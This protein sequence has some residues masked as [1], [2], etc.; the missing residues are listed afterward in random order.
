MERSILKAITDFAKEKFVL[1][2]GPRQ[3]GKTTLANQWR[4]DQ[5]LY[6]NWDIPEDRQVIL[7]KSFLKPL[8]SN[9]IV[10]D[11]L[12]KYDRWKSWLKG[13]YDQEA[14]RLAVLVTGSARL[15]VF[16]KGQDSL[17]GR[18]ERL[19]L[20][21]LSIGEL[22]HGKVFAPP[23]DWLKLEQL[24]SL[25]HWNQ[26]QEFSGFPEP[27]LKAD[28]KQKVRWSRQRKTLLINQDL[29]D[30]SEVK[31]ISLV[32]HLALLLP[33]K[34]GSP[35]SIN[36][37]RTQLEV[38]HSTIADWLEILE[39]LYYCFRI[40]PYS[41]QIAR[42]I[43]KET[44]LYLWDWTEIADKGARFENMVASHLLKAV[45]YWNDQGYGNFELQY[46]RNK[47][48]QEVDFIICNNYQPQ[49][50]IEC[51]DQ[52]V[53]LSK[54]LIEFGK[55]LADVPLIQLVNKKNIDQVKGNT[56]VVSAYKYLAELP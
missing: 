7:A 53:T 27:F 21:P 29:R 18:Y 11:E 28:S 12:H 42:A 50:L 19:R 46:L 55:Q 3:V 16:E 8:R 43:K 30:I 1:L 41:S 47:E 34:V 15:E 20:H 4:T 6:F 37:L 45:H 14:K 39:R 38:A 51:K 26:L 2:S 52:E 10:F 54:N 33:T 13:L 40:K 31:L 35:L 5:S 9:K 22:T 44:K 49:V 48:K 23:Q 36:R 24:S 25:D 56:R 32:E 17:L